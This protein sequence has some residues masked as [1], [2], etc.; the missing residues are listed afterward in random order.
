MRH[1][2][3]Q[4]RRLFVGVVAL[5]SRLPAL[6]SKTTTTIGRQI[7]FRSGGRLLL[8]PRPFFGLLSFA[9]D[10]TGPFVR[11]PWRK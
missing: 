2:A 6:A 4:P 8:F 3:S 5:L 11:G 9:G 7:S 1:F 10:G